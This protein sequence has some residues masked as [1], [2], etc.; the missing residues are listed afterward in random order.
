MLLQKDKLRSSSPSFLASYLNEGFIGQSK[1][2]SMGNAYC[3]CLIQP[4]LVPIQPV[5]HSTALNG[6]LLHLFSFQLS[7]LKCPSLSQVGSWPF[8]LPD[9]NSKE[10]CHWVFKYLSLLCKQETNPETW[11]Q[12]NTAKNIVHTAH[13]FTKD[14]QKQKQ[15]TKKV[16]YTCLV[17]STQ[18]SKWVNKLSNQTLGISVHLVGS[19]RGELGLNQKFQCERYGA[20]IQ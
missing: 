15:S 19:S 4:S 11:A 8:S 10:T 16:A 13:L 9:T 20:I 5:V 2:L 3:T 17:I 6:S 1:Y 7:P 18:M 12:P 14:I